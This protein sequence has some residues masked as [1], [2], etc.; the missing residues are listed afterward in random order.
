MICMVLFKL[1]SSRYNHTNKQHISEKKFSRMKRNMGGTD[2][3]K[4]LREKRHDASIVTA[5]LS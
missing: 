3:C 1:I 2:Y 5:N 4:V